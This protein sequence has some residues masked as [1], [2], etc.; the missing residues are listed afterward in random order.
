ML[1]LSAVVC[2]C[3]CECECGC[4]CEC[5]S[6]SVETWE[7]AKKKNREKKKGWDNPFDNLKMLQEISPISQ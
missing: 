1:V 5:V 4:K 2:E 3:E 6:V 7:I